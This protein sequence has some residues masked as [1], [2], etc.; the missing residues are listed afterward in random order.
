[1]L[2]GICFCLQTWETITSLS[3]ICMLVLDQIYKYPYQESAVSVQELQNIFEKPKYVDF[4]DNCRD[5]E[6]CV[7]GMMN[8]L[9]STMKGKTGSLHTRSGELF[10]AYL[11]LCVVHVV[12]FRSLYLSHIHSLDILLVLLY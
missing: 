5:L 2:S 7:S 10:L 9:V 3:A 6:V 12:I 11:F 4:S 1:M 8:Y